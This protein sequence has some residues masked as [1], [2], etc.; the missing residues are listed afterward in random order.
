MV[1]VYFLK[2]QSFRINTILK[3]VE[4]RF[5]IKKDKI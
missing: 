4:N 3:M 5:Q 1:T 2:I